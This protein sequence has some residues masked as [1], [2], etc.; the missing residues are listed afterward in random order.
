MA[1]KGES[2]GE[3]ANDAKSPSSLPSKVNSSLGDS[4]DSDSGSSSSDS[5]SPPERRRSRS[6]S[7]SRGRLALKS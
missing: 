2:E 4:S 1:A 5:D 3:E 7:P 6:P